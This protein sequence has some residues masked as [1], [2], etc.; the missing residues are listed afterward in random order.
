MTAKAQLAELTAW[1]AASS[2]DDVSPFGDTIKRSPFGQLVGITL[3]DLP[4]DLTAAIGLGCL[5]LLV[6]SDVPEATFAVSQGQPTLGER[7]AHVL[8]LS[9]AALS[10][11]LRGFR[12]CAV[13]RFQPGVTLRQATVA[14]GS[15]PN[16]DRLIVGIPAACF[17]E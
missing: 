15:D 16:A 9:Q 7:A 3:D 13:V 6:A 4:P 10:D 11:P 14:G 1:L 8:W 5:P 12:A 17:A 2:C